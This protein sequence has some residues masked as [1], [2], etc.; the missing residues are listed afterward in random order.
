MLAESGRGLRT[1]SLLARSWG[2][3]GNTYGGT[4]TA[5]FATDPTGVVPLLG[6][7]PENDYPDDKCELA[8][9]TYAL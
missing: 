8:G 7:R 6:A 1:V 9:A 4:V 2:W 3:H 5:V